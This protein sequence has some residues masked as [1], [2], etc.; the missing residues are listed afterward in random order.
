MGAGGLRQWIG[1]VRPRSS[2]ELSVD[3]VAAYPAG[4]LVVSGRHV[5]LPT[6]VAI[7]L[8]C[9]AHL[10][11]FVVDGS[12]DHIDERVI[13]YSIRPIGE[14]AGRDAWTVG[15]RWQVDTTAIS[16]RG[17]DVDGP[18]VDGTAALDQSA[19]FGRV[20]MAPVS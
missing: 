4:A 20:G 10:G 8:R 19:A 9:G 17:D 15:A 13:Y 12:H 2:D 3:V 7:S 5:Q 6:G 1:R 18:G 16:L 11:A 14:I